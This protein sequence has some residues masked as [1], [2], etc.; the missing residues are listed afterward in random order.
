MKIWKHI[1]THGMAVIRGRS[2][3]GSGL[4]LSIVRQLV[5]KMGGS[6]TVESTPGEKR[7]EFTLG[8]PLNE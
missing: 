2:Q 6:I 8:F 4:G 7:T 3:K 5:E 1:L